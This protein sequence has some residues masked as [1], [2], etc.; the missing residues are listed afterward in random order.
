MTG[1][2]IEKSRTPLNTVQRA[3]DIL[4][5]GSRGLTTSGRV[6]GQ[7][8]RDSIAAAPAPPL[9]STGPWKCTLAGILAHRPN[10]PLL[11][12][13]PLTLLDRFGAVHLD[14]VQVGFDGEQHDWTRVT[15]VRMRNAFELLTT[16]ALEQEVDRIRS[17]FPPLP[18]RK[19]TL[20]FVAENLATVL[21]AALDQGDDALDRAIVGEVRYRGRLPGTRT[22]RPGLFASALLS[23]RPDI[24]EALLA[25]AAQRGIPITAAE[26]STRRRA[27]AAAEREERINA[28][29][30]RTDAII[31][32]LHA[33]EPEPEDAVQDESPA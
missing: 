7:W 17:L 30:Q 15:A 11:K 19:K 10:S 1:N 4:T 6:G 12:L 32:R 9:P 2:D 21:L 22:V 24:G 29:R 14:T 27:D 33:E 18:G 3:R 26:D 16:D 5:K 20:T 13:R 28:L 25:E 8:I 23:L 31:T